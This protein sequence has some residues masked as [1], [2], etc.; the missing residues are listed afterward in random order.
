MAKTAAIMLGDG[1][2]P[3]EAV[4]PLDAL[5]RG[6]VQVTTVSVM[7]RKDVTAA[8]DVP[9]IADALVEDADLDGFDVVIVPGGSVGVENLGKCAKLGEALKRRMAAGKMVASIC[10]GPTVLAELGLLEGRR[11]TC[12]PGCETVFPAGVY[13]KDKVVVDE[14]LITSE[15]PGTALDFGIAVL[16]A[17]A[18][19]AAADRV[20]AGMLLGEQ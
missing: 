6:G 16:R 18:G 8:Q 7:G 15:G 5:R 13:V 20:A 17:V 9:V 4:A 14:N 11:A 3:V 2:E 19:D 1:F 12:Y 10:A